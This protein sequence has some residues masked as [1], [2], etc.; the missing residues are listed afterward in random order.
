MVLTYRLPA[1]TYPASADH[2]QLAA[3]AAVLLDAATNGNA[4]L[5]V[6]AARKLWMFR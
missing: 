1:T 3:A 2:R 4:L 6:H 5:C